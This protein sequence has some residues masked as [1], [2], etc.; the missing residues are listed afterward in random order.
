MNMY[1]VIIVV[2]IGFILG[3]FAIPMNYNEYSDIITFI[4]IMIGFQSTAFAM[5]Y[6]SPMRKVLWHTKNSEH[7]TELHNIRHMFKLSF[8]F[9]MI[10]VSLLFL[11]F[12]FYNK[13]MGNN[14][15]LGYSFGKHS[16]VIPIISGIIY[17]FIILNRHLFDL[18]THPTND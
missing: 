14:Q 11:P 6:A 2:V 1:K 9:E 16:L 10:S 8:Y 12:E 15:L 7:I 17:M 4:S 13:I 3:M 5:Y 18:F